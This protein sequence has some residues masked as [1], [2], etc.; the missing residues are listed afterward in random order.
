MIPRSA[1][2]HRITH[3]PWEGSGA[4]GPVWGTPTYDVPVYIEPAFR[5]VVDAK[6]KTI[7]A[8]ATMLAL[9]DM[10]IAPEDRITW[11]RPITGITT[12]Y[13]VID[14]Q[15]IAGSHQ[16]VLLTSLGGA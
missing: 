1:L 4:L 12:E 9:P 7:T 6:G 10:V 11:V 8:T 5:T 16:E 3:T 14:A 13:Q 15:P 2:R